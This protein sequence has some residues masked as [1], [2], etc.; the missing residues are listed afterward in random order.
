MTDQCINCTIRGNLKQCLA[1]DCFQHENWM[2]IE[3]R[4]ENERLRSALQRIS[5]STYGDLSAQVIAGDT[6]AGLVPGKNKPSEK[7]DHAHGLFDD[8]DDWFHD[9]DMEARG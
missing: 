8:D 3:L 4:A 7:Q 1:T 9:S 5:L 6:L 2:A